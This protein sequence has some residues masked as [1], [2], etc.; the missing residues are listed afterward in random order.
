MRRVSEEGKTAISRS[1]LSIFHRAVLI[2]FDD[3]LAEA[4]RA[5][6]SNFAPKHSP[7]QTSLSPFPFSVFDPKL[8]PRKRQNANLPVS[9]PA[10]SP[11]IVTAQVQPAKIY[12]E[13]TKNEIND[14][15]R[16]HVYHNSEPTKVNAVHARQ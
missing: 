1:R 2:I 8:F 6:K 7:S 14:V 11:C 13:P 10:S 9:S 16:A 3:Q 12:A 15:Q 4:L 5:G